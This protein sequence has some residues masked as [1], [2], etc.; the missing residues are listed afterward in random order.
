MNLR[1]EDIKSSAVSKLA[2]NFDFY[3]LM[4][5]FAAIVYDQVNARLPSEAQSA[6][7]R[8]APSV[9][10]ASRHKSYATIMKK[11]VTSRVK[12]QD[13]AINPAELK[14]FISEALQKSEML[15]RQSTVTLSILHAFDQ[16]L[17]PCRLFFDYICQSY[18]RPQAF[19]FNSPTLWYSLTNEYFY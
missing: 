8:V 4:P 10:Q 2:E 13:P 1:L 15:S 19:T 11:Y 17:E 7:R 14:S 12:P 16:D 5:E 6:L 18:P 9:Y 3:H